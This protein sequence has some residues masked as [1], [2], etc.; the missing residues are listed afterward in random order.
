MGTLPIR[1]LNTPITNDELVELRSSVKQIMEEMNSDIMD[2]NGTLRH[3]IRLADLIA[4]FELSPAILC[5]GLRTES[6]QGLDT[7]Y[8]RFDKDPEVSELQKELRE[9]YQ[10]HCNIPPTL[11]GDTLSAQTNAVRSLME[12]VGMDYCFQP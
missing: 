4:L 11:Y 9:K 10:G 7:W 3:D 6:L 1:V 8:K 2:R 12:S 5:L